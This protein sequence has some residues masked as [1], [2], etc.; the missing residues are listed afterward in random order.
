MASPEALRVLRQLQQD[1][2]NKVGGEGRPARVFFIGRD[3]WRLALCCPRAT[4]RP[5]VYTRTRRCVSLCV[6]WW[7]Q[8][9]ARGAV[10]GVGLRTSRT[11][12][13]VEQGRRGLPALPSCSASARHRGHRCMEQ[14]AMGGMREGEPL[15]DSSPP[16]LSA[17]LAPTL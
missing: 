2:A 13:L 10:A 9:R 3:W 4:A 12:G 17:P 8:A 15:F 1:P 7:R 14:S 5:L 16:P 11:A 6:R